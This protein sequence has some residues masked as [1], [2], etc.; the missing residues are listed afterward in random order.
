MKMLTKKNVGEDLIQIMIKIWKSIGV[1]FTSRKWYNFTEW[2][3]SV[4]SIWWS[5]TKTLKGEN[6]Q[7]YYFLPHMPAYLLQNSSGWENLCFTIID[8]LLP[9]SKNSILDFGHSNQSVLKRSAISLA[10]VLFSVIWVIK[11]FPINSWKSNLTNKF[12]K[13]SQYSISPSLIW[14]KNY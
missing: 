4:L 7:L 14:K 2:F 13:T 9:K 12:W 1:T 11:S 3:V 5:I 8:Y 6:C 10:V